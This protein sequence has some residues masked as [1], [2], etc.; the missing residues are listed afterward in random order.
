MTFSKRIFDLFFAIALGL[1][2]LPAFLILLSVLLITEGRPLFY[3]SERMRTPTQPF[4]LI[5]LRTMPRNSGDGGVTGGNKI[6]TLSRTQR[7][8][9][10]SRAD[11]LP[12]LWNVIRGDISLVGPRPP[13]RVYVDANPEL[14]GKVLQSRPGITGLASLRFHAH[15]EALLR[16]CKS[17]AE[18]DEVYRRRCVPR[19]AQLDL[20]YQRKRGI[21]FDIVLL[22]ETAAKPFQR[23]SK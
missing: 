12:Q 2:L 17:A 22:L 11:E 21:C 16:Q 15:E 3:V 9:R 5:K 20:I 14:Y 8:L 18:T 6:Q 7:I 13:L 23:H 10:A 4:Y 19:K 1:I